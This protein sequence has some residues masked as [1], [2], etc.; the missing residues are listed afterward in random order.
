MLPSVFKT[1]I[2][3]DEILAGEQFRPSDE[4]ETKNSFPINIRDQWD[5]DYSNFHNAIDVTEN[6][7]K[8][9]IKFIKEKYLEID[10]ED[11]NKIA[12]QSYN[13]VH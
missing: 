3:R 11:S 1:C 12:I 9:L 5:I 10:I 13:S 2:P 7:L 6:A 8:K 4:Y